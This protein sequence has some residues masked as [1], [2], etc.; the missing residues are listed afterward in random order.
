MRIAV[1]TSHTIQYNAPLFV[2]L[3]KREGLEIQ[4]FYC[5]QGSSE[6]VDAEFGVPVHWDVPLLEGYDYTFVPNKASKP[7]SYHFFG[8][9]N[10]EMTSRIS[11]WNPDVLL[12]YGWFSKTHISVL[13]YFKGRLPVFF[14]GDST[15]LFG[16]SGVRGLVRKYFLKWVYRQVDHAFYVGQHNKNYFKA[17]GLAESQ[18]H[19][20]PHSIDNA[21]YKK[22]VGDGR[23]AIE[24]ARQSLGIAQDDL[25][26]LFAGKLVDRKKPLLLLD[27]FNKIP[28]PDGGAHSHLVFVG[29][30]AQFS[31]LQEVS[32]GNDRIHLVGFQN[33]SM[34][35]I[36]Y[37]L[38]TVFVLPSI[39]E[40]WGLGVNEAMASGKPC[41]VSDL[42]GC[43][44]NLVTPGK[45][46]EIFKNGSI[47]SLAAAMLKYVKDPKLANRQQRDVTDRIDGWST[48]CT[49]DR[50]C[51][52]FKRVY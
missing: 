40:T 28:G 19:W 52:V 6:V 48:Q 1:L 49:A 22:R 34:M 23:Q 35:P 41:I 17:F 46:G 3:S 37:G 47:E 42:V 29:D 18:L 20:A 26:F 25:V 51:E 33:Q 12:V 32:A 27:A 4:V 7:G 9:D 10:P 13:R 36:Y 38:S 30:G 24:I 11:E 14:R 43:G 39:R 8:L 5:W 16:N 45:T 31:R 15:L 44:P 21:Q 50:M 2:E